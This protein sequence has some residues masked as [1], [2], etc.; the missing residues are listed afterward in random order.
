MIGKSPL[1]NIEDVNGLRNNPSEQGRLAIIQ[2]V[3][4][5]YIHNHSLTEAERDLAEE[6][7]K[8]AANDVA[9]IVKETL[10]EQLRECKDIPQ[11]LV[12][13]LMDNIDV[14]HIVLPFLQSFEGFS[15]DYLLEIISSH[16][17][18]RQKAIANRR[19]VSE[20]VSD[21]LIEEGVRDVISTLTA[22]QGAV[23]SQKGYHQIYEK[24]R[25]D[26]DIK[27]NLCMRSNLPIALAERLVTEVS[28]GLRD[29]LLARY[30][31]SP[32]IANKVTQY[33]QEK[34]TLFIAHPNTPIANLQK[35]I[36][37]LKDS[38]RLTDT[39]ILR[40]ICM[41]DM[42]FFNF[43]LAERAGV[44]VSALQKAYFDKD[45]KSMRALLVKA[46]ISSTLHAPMLIGVQVYREA[47]QE[48]DMANIETF[49][50]R[51]IERFLTQFPAVGAYTIDH[52]LDKLHGCSRTSAYLM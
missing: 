12:A 42:R 26:V 5:H 40:A 31:I 32:T 11:S 15:D 18:Q 45:E 23:I 50:R 29:Q 51:V 1:I 4:T 24:F 22:N 16:C 19:T 27:R 3:T 20:R 34:V 7:I 49:S 6:I 37:H 21:K 41:G 36:H 10:I 47:S 14:A 48:I 13:E 43:S 39:L 52:L 46:N 17:P 25:D 9:N 30:K 33:A 28:M 8:I 38:K 2:K 44:P 35:L